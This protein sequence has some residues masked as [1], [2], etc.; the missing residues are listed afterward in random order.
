VGKKVSVTC[1]NCG[2]AFPRTVAAVNA[3]RKYKAGPFCSKSCRNSGLCKGKPLSPEHRKKLSG[4]KPWNKGQA[5]SPEVR[6]KIA[7]RAADGSR[8]MERNVNWHGGRSVRQ[9][10]YI[11]IRVDGRPKL[12]HRHLMELHLGRKLRPGEVVHHVNDD[13]TDNRLEN[14]QL[15]TPSAHMKHHNPH[16]PRRVQRTVPCRVCGTPFTTTATHSPGKLVCRRPECRQQQEHA[17]QAKY[18]AKNRKPPASI[19]CSICGQEF[20]GRVLVNAKYRVC[21]RPSCRVEYNRR[22][23]REHRIALAAKS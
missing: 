6:R 17:Y 10:G 4:R 19:K 5:W 21:P 14:L 18:R 3:G 11:Q 2:K 12:E 15:T 7:V 8:A 20:P 22:H 13:K 23:C 16:G 1:V 9:D